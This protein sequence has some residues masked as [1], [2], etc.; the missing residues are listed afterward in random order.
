MHQ[1]VL[2]AALNSAEQ[3]QYDQMQRR[4]RFYANTGSGG[5]M[6]SVGYCYSATAF[7]S[8]CGGGTKGDIVYN[9][10]PTPGGYLGWVCTVTG[11]PGTWKPFGLIAS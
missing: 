5:R 3:L 8:A 11:T 10:A 7:A 2:L 4:L 6:Q 1:G 9:T